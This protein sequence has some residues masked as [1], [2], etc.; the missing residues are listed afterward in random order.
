MDEEQELQKALDKGVEYAHPAPGDKR[1]LSAIPCITHGLE[2]DCGCT[3]TIDVEL[4]LYHVAV[5]YPGLLGKALDAFF[6]NHKAELAMTAL[7]E[8]TERLNLHG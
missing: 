4:D 7:A 6:E 8:E 1:R 5:L 2:P 3:A